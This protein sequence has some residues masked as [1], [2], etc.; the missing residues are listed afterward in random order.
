[1]TGNLIRGREAAERATKLTSFMVRYNNQLDR[2]WPYTTVS[3]IAEVVSEVKG[4]DV[5]LE[6]V[7]ADYFE[8]IVNLIPKGFK[9]KKR[10]LGGLASSYD[11]PPRAT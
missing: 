10:E 5:A 4:M 2:T 3:R 1:M 7:D 8:Y 9:K 11:S 6:S